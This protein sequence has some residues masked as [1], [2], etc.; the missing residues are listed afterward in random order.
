LNH[1]RIVAV[2]EVIDEAGEAF[3]T[4]EYVEGETL[5]SAMAS[6]RFSVRETIDILSQIALALDFAHDRGVIHGDLKPSEIFLPPQ[7]TVKVAILGSRLWRIGIP[8]G[9]YRRTFCTISSPEHLRA[10]ESVDARS[11]QYSLAVIAYWMFTGRPVRPDCSRSRRRDPG[12]RSSPSTRLDAQL[13]PSLDG[14]ILRALDHTP[15]RRFESCRKFVGSWVR[16]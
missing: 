1:P 11:D 9:R 13:P 5:A 6:R 7:Q 16:G 4:S 3:V 15:A 2:Q 8:G 14:P 12:S 10:P